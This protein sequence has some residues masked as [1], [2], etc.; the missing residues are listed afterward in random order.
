MW[1][2][3]RHSHFSSQPDFD[4]ESQE[5]MTKASSFKLNKVQATRLAFGN[6]INEEI[7]SQEKE[8]MLVNR[9]DESVNQA[10]L[11]TL[12][13]IRHNVNFLY[14]SMRKVRSLV[15]MQCQT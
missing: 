6:M 9:S 14:L 1:V 10:L 11:D 4:V 12:I 3:Y 15:I 13:T 2:S 7:L 8:T 5:L